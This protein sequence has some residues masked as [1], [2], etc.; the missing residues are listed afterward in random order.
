MGEMQ[1][2]GFQ[3][4]IVA[5]STP[6]GRGGLGVVRL[7]GSRARS[8]VD[9]ML[10]LGRPLAHAQACFGHLLDLQGPTPE[11][12]DEVVVT[13]Y[14]APRS[15]TTE[16]VVEVS[17]HG[18]PVLLDALL[19]A[20]VQ[21]GAR[22]GEPGEFTQR[23]FLSGRLDLT[24]AEAVH[25]LIES[26]TLHQARTAARQLGGALSQQIRPVKEKLIHLIAGLE[27]EIDFAEDDLEGTSPLVLQRTL[28]EIQRPL[29]ALEHS[30]SYGRLVREGCR[31]AIVGRPNAGKSSL[32]N[33][34]L[35]HDRAIV[36]ASPGTTRD[37]VTDHLA[38]DGIP[39]EL[40]D[41]AGI[42]GSGA[43]QVM[44]DDAGTLDEAER[45]GINKSRQAMAEADLI[46]LVHDVTLGW[47]VDEM[48][49][50]AADRGVPCLIVLNKYDLIAE[51]ESANSKELADSCQ[52]PAAV[53][54]RSPR[55]ATNTSLNGDRQ[56]EIPSILT[57]TLTGFGLQ[58]LRAAISAALTHGGSI[59]E[60]ASLTN[61]RQ[62]QAV[63]SSIG[64]LISAQDASRR[65]LPEEVVLLDLHAALHALD[66][67][68]GA[69]STEDILTEIFS[70][71]CIGK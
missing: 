13:F 25:D 2:P 11:I 50:M 6:P 5:V 17:T 70:S 43:I 45:M 65:H 68:T 59:S 69:T 38:L 14:A 39:V 35:G 36:T 60:T 1:S 48:A 30:A 20:C 67:L 28:E 34:L 21:R 64:Y 40:L 53:T 46:L 33:A 22:L 19:S 18:S 54:D 37:V 4:T 41:T 24:Q 16:D 57:S 26:T 10:R 8:I 9:P 15:Y 62:H 56:A 31:I 58:E 52:I 63:R 66:L 61:L 29:Q 55:S 42:R 12:L 47:H 71:F 51:A 32:F 23:A 49:S 27:A 3:D 44:N 7:S